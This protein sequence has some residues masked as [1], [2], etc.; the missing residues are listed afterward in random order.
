[1]LQ[2]GQGRAELG[3][4]EF[5]SGGRGLAPFED[6]GELGGDSGQAGGGR[7]G[8][9]VGHGLGA[10]EGVDVDATQFVAVPNCGGATLASG[11]GGEVGAKLRAG[12][13]RLGGVEITT[14]RGGVAGRQQLQIGEASRAEQQ[15]L[16]RL[17]S[18]AIGF[19]LGVEA[20]PFLPE[21]EDGIGFAGNRWIRDDGSGVAEPAAG[22][23]PRRGADAPLVFLALAMIRASWQLVFADNRLVGDALNPHQ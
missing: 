2:V 10:F 1:M 11:K 15:R 12:G 19:R 7:A 21:D 23:V 5:L 14:R 8:Q 20:L 22:T 9:A 18:A 6:E 16:D 17:P 3:P 4:G 13:S